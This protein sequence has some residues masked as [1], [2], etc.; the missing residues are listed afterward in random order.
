MR[1]EEYVRANPSSR[2]GQ[3]PPP[4]AM[5]L[6]RA[7]CGGLLASSA[8]AGLHIAT[9]GGDAAVRAQGGGA[10]AMIY[11][12]KLSSSQGVAMAGSHRG[13]P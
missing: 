5:M 1:K 10:G 13:P 9:R 6:L 3:P 7:P 4:A 11:K 8:E 12:P 2:A